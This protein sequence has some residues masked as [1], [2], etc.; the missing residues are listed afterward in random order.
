MYFETVRFD[1]DWTVNLFEVTIRALGGLLS[2]HLIAT[3]LQQEA[4]LLHTSPTHGEMEYEETERYGALSTYQLQLIAELEEYLLIDD[5][6]ITH[7]TSTQQN[8][9]QQQQ[10]QPQSKS[11]ISCN[12]YQ[13][14]LLK[15][16]ERTKNRGYFVE[17]KAEF[18]KLAVDLG[19]RLLPAFQTKTGVPYSRINLKSGVPKGETPHNCLA[20]AGTLL[21]EFAT[22]GRLSG[23]SIFEVFI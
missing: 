1:N 4:S 18:L 5:I 23:Y 14:H 16:A 13:Y 15:Q 6:D 21:L 7:Q 19:L 22:L 11:P 20:G 12:D 10:Q 2:S 8:Q 17:Y 3:Q 9:Q